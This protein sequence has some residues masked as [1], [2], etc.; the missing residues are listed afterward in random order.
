LG[1]RLADRL[2]RDH[3]DGLA[4]VDHDAASEVTPV[5][6]RADATAGLARE[7]RA[8][9]H[10]GDTGVVDD[11]DVVLGDIGICRNQD[12]ARVRIDD[13]LE[14][15]AT[16]DAVPEALDD[17]A[18]FDQRHHLDT[19]AGTAVE[20]ADGGVLRHVDEAAGQVT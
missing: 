16:Q 6:Q 5:A 10:A 19:L 17:L 15:D 12:L 1:T 7:H 4:D 8:D 11:L 20:L 9:L 14:D 13:V 18:T 3:T 2:R